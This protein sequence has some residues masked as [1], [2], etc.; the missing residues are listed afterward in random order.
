[1]KKGIFAVIIVTLGF[2]VLAVS[3]EG[4]PEYGKFPAFVLAGCSSGVLWWF[5][6]LAVALIR[7]D[8]ILLW[9]MGLSLLG[10]VLLLASALSGT[11]A[12]GAFWGA[13]IGIAAFGSLTI[14]VLF[15]RLAYL[16]LKSEPVATGQRR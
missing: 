12:F 6:A 2:F 4:D 9:A 15:T 8:R 5:T 16:T 3:A 1:M 13:S 14:L 7:K 11:N 10:F